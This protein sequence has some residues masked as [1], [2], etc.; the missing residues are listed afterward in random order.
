MVEFTIVN[1]GVNTTQEILMWC[2]EHYGLPFDSFGNTG[3]W[4]LRTMQD[5]LYL[6]FLREEDATLFKLR[7]M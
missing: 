7:W 1:P 5:L 2:M 3:T 6:C 4:R